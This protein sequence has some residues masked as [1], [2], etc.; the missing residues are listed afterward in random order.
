M[1]LKIE[2]LVASLKDGKLSQEKVRE[3]R[4]LV[5]QLLDALESGKIRVAEPNADGWKVNE[6]VKRGILA[7]FG[8]SDTVVY[9]G[10]MTFV[11]KDLYT[12]R[13]FDASSGARIVGPGAGARRGAHLGNGVVFMSPAWANVGA[14]VGENSMVES[15]AGSCAQIGKNCHI[16]AGTVIGGVL[17]PVEATPVILGDYVLLG[18]SSGVTQGSRLGD[19]VTLAP[20]VHISKATP[21]LDPINSLAYTSKGIAELIEEQVGSVKIY[22]VGEITQPKDDTY[23]PE[24]PKGALVIPGMTVSSSGTFKMAPMIAKYIK[25]PSERAYALEE[26]LR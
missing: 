23:G 5:N 24:V 9:G 1:Q 11:D 25:D 3:G 17:D 8:L 16:S 18:E 14:Y 2:A 10:E 15:L 22:R 6:W 19:L 12:L 7:G 20:G 4:E 21:V 26:A 13:K